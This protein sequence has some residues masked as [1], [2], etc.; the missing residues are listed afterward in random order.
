MAYPTLNS[1][2]IFSAL[3]NQI[4]SIQTYADNIAGTFSSLVDSARV[5]GTL[6]GDTKVYIATDALES[7]AWGNDAEAANLLN[8]K[9]PPAPKTQTITLD[10]F[11]Q[12]YVTVDDYLSKRAFSDE[13]AFSQF[14]SVV[15]GW[16]GDTKRIYDSTTYN[17]YIGSAKTSTGKQVTEI[18][19]T[20]ATTGL[21]GEAKARMTGM[22]IAKGIADL[23]TD[24]SDISRNYN[25]NE[26]LRSYNVDDLIFVWNSDKAHEVEKI[27]LPTIY[28]K[29]IMDKFGEY[30]LPA[31]YFGEV[32]A[33]GHEA[34]ANKVINAS[35]AYDNTKGTLRSCIEQTI[36][37]SGTAYHVFAG[38]EL[39]NG[40]TIGTVSSSALATV[41]IECYEQKADILC[42]VMHR[43]SVP[44]MSAFEV[45]TSFF[46]PKSLTDTQYLS[47]GH[48][49]LAYLKQYPF[50]TV[51]VK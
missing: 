24:V 8:L 22:T 38:D 7:A 4:I 42:K 17:A 15:K 43:S 28:H 49:T 14:N 50:I 16:I 32:V 3:Y 25:D 30:V 9:R 27:D 19:V 26:F 34:D 5:D 33:V 51:K 23:L 21:S 37:V 36:T 18:D 12:I 41:A 31:R 10:K 29:E 44:Y 13:G 39:P 2:E 40:A 6:Y 20:T 45:G 1:N 46:N 48:N 47:W 35:G 11:R